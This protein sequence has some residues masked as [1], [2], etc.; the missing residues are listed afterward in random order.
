MQD[1]ILHTL[2]QISAVLWGPYV[3]IPLLVVT[4]AWLTFLLRGI[5]FRR[6]GYGLWLAFVVRKDN[7]GNGDISQ[8]QSLMTALAATV[9]TGNIVGVATAIALGGPGALFWLWVMGLIG[10]ATKYAEAVLAVKYRVIDERGEA[11]GG[12]MYYLSLGFRH[13]RIGRVLAVLFAFFTACAAFGIG[14]MVQA[15]SIAAAMEQSFGVSPL[16]TGI[17]ITIIAATIVLGGVR[18]VGR[19]SGVL[20][21]VMI[22]VYV[23]TVLAILLL[24]LDRVPHALSVVIDGA[25]SSMAPV[26]GFVGATFAQAMRYGLARGIFSN[27]AGMGSGGIASAAA[28]TTEPVRQALVAMMQTFVDTVVVCGATGIAII[29][30]GAWETGLKG[31]E[32]TQLAFNT[33]LHMALGSTFSAVGGYIV[34]FTLCMFAFSTIIGWGFYGEKGVEYLLGARAVYPYRIVFLMSTVL[35]AVAQLTLVWTFAD[36]MN[37]LMALPNLVGLLALSTVVLAE[38]RSHFARHPGKGKALRQAEE[39]HTHTRA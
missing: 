30:T 36:V 25:F 5:Q 11:S 16:V 1:Q 39:R 14:N 7:E 8:F 18:S 12:A 38:T 13:A 9:G 10:M 27:E 31:V 21:P 23:A 22:L 34:T 33:G 20:V 15:N 37:G 17:V 6:L 4:G 19:V 32:V 28:Q 3:L 24:N 26:G 29:L 2:E 35:G